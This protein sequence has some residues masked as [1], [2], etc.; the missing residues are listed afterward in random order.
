MA[1]ADITA[2]LSL[3]YQPHSAVNVDLIA[4]Y[5]DRAA[6]PALVAVTDVGQTGTAS[7]FV[8]RT[9]LDK[10]LK[11]RQ[12]EFDDENS[13]QSETW[14]LT[15]NAEIDLGFA[16]LGVITGFRDWSLTGEQDSDST[17]LQLFTNSGAI[18]AQQISTEIRLASAGDGA[19]TW[20]I[21][22][23]LLHDETDV[24]FAIRNYQGLF[25]LG[26]NAVFNAAQKNNAYAAFAD[27]VYELTDQLSLTAGIRYSY[28]TKN[29]NNDLVVSILN[30]GTAPPSFMSGA[31][32]AAGDVFSD[33]PVFADKA[34][35]DDISPRAIVEF[36]PDDDVHLYASYSQGFKSGG[37]NSFGLTPAFSSESVHA[38]EVGVKSE[39]ADRRIRLN[40][41][42]FIYDYSNLQIRLPVP[43]GGVDIR[44]V[45]ASEIKGVET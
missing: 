11:G 35:F 8:L 33:P 30:G 10:V 26:T 14:S 19:L 43:S 1:A 18:G 22:G 45:A 16:S 31:V 5:Q 4:E 2:R 44:N 15:A 28:E 25:G 27:A 13:T 3:R 29:F 40:A 38:Y 37:F 12:F 20:L 24:D 32:F 23:F 17:G 9:D 7:P 36:K 42:A 34:S 39:L 6:N 41:S 21:G